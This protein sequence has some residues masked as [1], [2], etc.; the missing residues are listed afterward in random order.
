MKHFLN[1]K[2]TYNQTQIIDIFK[3]FIYI[4]SFKNNIQYFNEYYIKEK[5]TPELVSYR[6]Y[7]TTDYWWIILS[8]NNIYDP[9]Y[10]WPLSEEE[11]EL[12]IKKLYPDWENDI[13]SYL[14]S[15]EEKRIENSNKKQIKI[16]KSEYID[17]L[18]KQ[19]KGLK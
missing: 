5:E 15:L 12:W 9:F 2:I 7:N 8:F 11:L 18:I 17:L 13:P 6:F 14:Q 19:I 1:T 16:L 10:D 3:K 4:E